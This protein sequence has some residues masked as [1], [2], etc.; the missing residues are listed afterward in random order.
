MGVLASLR[1]RNN[2]IKKSMK[3]VEICLFYDFA[4]INKQKTCKLRQFF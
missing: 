2:A 1:L 3:F 4:T